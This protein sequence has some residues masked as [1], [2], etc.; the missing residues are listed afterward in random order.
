MSWTNVRV[1][2]YNLYLDPI[3]HTKFSRNRNWRI[4][5]KTILSWKWHFSKMSVRQLTSVAVDRWLGRLNS[6]SQERFMGN[7]DQALSATSQPPPHS[8]SA[9]KTVN[10]SP[11]KC[12][13]EIWNGVSL[14]FPG[15][16]SSLTYI[17]VASWISNRCKSLL[18]SFLLCGVSGGPP[19]HPTSTSWSHRKNV[20]HLKIR[21]SSNL[22]STCYFLK[23]I[24]RSKTSRPSKT[25]M[26][27]NHHWQRMI[28]LMS[29]RRSFGSHSL[30]SV[31]IR[32]LWNFASNRPNN[33]TKKTRAQGSPNYPN[34]PYSLRDYSDNTPCHRNRDTL[35]QVEKFVMNFNM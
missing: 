11:S 14:F 2:S 35:M 15:V 21:K 33:T 25:S 30:T 4:M 18:P 1:L 34:T 22:S 12:R 20:T 10:P 8:K 3:G 24:G 5:A 27:Q 23:K 26:A 19:L 31:C 28:S 13:G 17:S 7:T 9:K 32:E 29:E 16:L 6:P